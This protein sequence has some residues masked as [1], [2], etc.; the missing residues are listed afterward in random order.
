MFGVIK[1]VTSWRLEGGPGLGCDRYYPL[2][3]A[4]KQLVDIQTIY[5]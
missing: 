4:G 1:Y 3:A 5:V 2:M